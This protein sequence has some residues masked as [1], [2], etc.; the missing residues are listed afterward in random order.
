VKRE[1]ERVGE[2]ERM[3]GMEEEGREEEEKT[4]GVSRQ[5]TWLD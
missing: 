2:R 5:F 4:F 1:K 3:E